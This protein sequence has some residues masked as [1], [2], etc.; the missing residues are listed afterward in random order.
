MGLWL[1]HSWKGR[2][3][4]GITPWRKDS[5]LSINNPVLTST[6]VS[7]L[8]NH[9]FQRVISWYLPRPTNAFPIQCTFALMSSS[10]GVL[11]PKWWFITHLSAPNQPTK[12][13]AL[14]KCTR[15]CH[16]HNG[17]H[18]QLFINNMGLTK[19]VSI[20]IRL[21]IGVSYTLYADSNAS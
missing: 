9:L 12:R 14:K 20:A 2:V 1:V 7:A 17:W 15:W 18:H 21:I 5:R 13:K 8:P 3:N 4:L 6:T 19:I 11:S 16:L 10:I